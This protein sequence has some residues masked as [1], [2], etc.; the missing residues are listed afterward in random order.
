MKF[1]SVAVFIFNFMLHFCG[2]IFCDARGPV[3]LTSRH[4]LFMPAPLVFLRGGDF[5]NPQARWPLRPVAAVSVF[6]T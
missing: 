1:T 3:I 5:T 4:M 2:S 6:K